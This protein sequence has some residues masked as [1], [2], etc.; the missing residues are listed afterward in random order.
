[1]LTTILLVSI[2]SK[3][4]LRQTTA[5]SI[6]PWMTQVFQRNSITSKIAVTSKERY[7]LNYNNWSADEWDDHST[8]MI[9]AM[10]LQSSELDMLKSK[11]I[12]SELRIKELKD[13][14]QKAEAKSE[15]ELFRLENIKNNDEL[16]KLYTGIPD[17]ATLMIF[18]EEVLKGDAEVMRI[19]KGKHCKDDFDELKCGYQK[20]PLEQ[21][22]MT[23]VRLRMAFPE[24]DLAN[25]FS[26]S[27]ST[28]SRI[29]MT[30]V[31]LLYHNFKAFHHGMWLTNTCLR[32]SNSITQTLEL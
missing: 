7:N 6:F 28:V 30:W 1:M 19:W 4:R 8:T 18:Y 5:P 21:L 22:F 3:H 17:Y 10:N 27:Q 16:V 2:R 23:L 20:L 32:L 31:N 29:M 25:R 14:L 12:E 9:D 11:V 24:L 13:E 15:S 26:V